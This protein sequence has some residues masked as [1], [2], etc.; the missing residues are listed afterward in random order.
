VTPDKIE[1]S[2]RYTALLGEY[3]DSLEEAPLAE[4]EILGQEMVLSNIPPEEI[5]EM[6]DRAIANLITSTNISAE[7]IRTASLPLM[8]LLM[9]YGVAFRSML[10]KKEAEESLFLASKAIENT[11]DG[12]IITDADTH[13]V[14]VNRSFER[15]TGYSKEEVVGKTP[16]VLHSGNQDKKFYLQ[17]WESIN[18]KGEWQGKLWNRKK[19][20][21]EYPEYLSIT[22]IKNDEDVIT[23]YVGV[24]SDISEQLSLE[25]QFQQAQKMEAIGTLVG[26]IAHD[27]NNML[28]GITGNIYLAK[29]R[30][31]QGELAEAI[32]KISG[33][34]E[35]SQRAA[36]MI[37]QLLTFARKGIVQMSELSM[38]SFVKES[39]KLAQVTI[40]E[41]IQVIHEI[42]TED[43]LIK[44]DITQLQQVLL[45][46]LN[47]ARDAVKDIPDPCIKLRLSRFVPDDM[48]IKQHTK[49]HA[50]AFAHLQVID[51]GQ[52]IAKEHLNQ[53][54]DPFFTTKPTG[55]GTGLG[56]SMVF[57]AI[58]THEGLIEVES[59]QG[60]RTTFHIYL[61]LIEEITEETTDVAVIES[62]KA[63]GETILLAD[64]ETHVRETTAEV[65]E[66]LGY[67]V[68]QAKD[69]IEAIEQI[70]TY[71][72]KVSLAILDV[73]MP[74]L[75]GI[76]LAKR[77]RETDSDLPI[78]FVTGYDK[79]H[80]LGAGEAMPH[81]EI[82]TKPVNFDVLGHSIRKLLREL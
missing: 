67:C 62:L 3:A 80:V 70:K 68:L 20:G 43:V 69:G 10:A 66:S 65:L 77:I 37:S 34:E 53:V 21:D 24:F 23:N 40:P 30:I 60:K 81:S 73:I 47:N 46:L 11:V 56:L 14:S 55:K 50:K 25:Q 75:G 5:G 36:T 32:D 45:N 29:L 19:N 4:I 2:N 63:E 35:L 61:P 12:I 58:Q 7:K 18:S 48:F 41:N 6:H 38:N 17:M 76:P 33:V 26:G 74:R 28:A 71:R 16:Q 51:N 44:G 82:L 8:Q 79:E 64:D 78:V 54:F 39:I 27:F 22:A 49:F 52:G 59:I 9:S 72:G 31:E 1:F 57:G 42:T 15:V 13:I